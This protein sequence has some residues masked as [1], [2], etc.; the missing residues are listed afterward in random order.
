MGVKCGHSSAFNFNRI[1][2]ILAANE[3]VHKS[4][5]E[6]EFRPDLTQTTELAAL[7]CLRI[8]VSTFSRS[9]LILSFLKLHVSRTYIIV[10]I[11][12]RITATLDHRQQLAGLEH[13]KIPHRLIMGKVVSSRFLGCFLSD[14]FYIFR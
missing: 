8:I 12:V 4:L 14:S 9:L 7:E 3:S 6:F 5:N 11:I 10:W 13:L 2:F 1:F